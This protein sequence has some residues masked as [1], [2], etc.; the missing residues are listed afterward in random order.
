MGILSGVRNVVGFLTILPVGMDSDALKIAAKHVYL[1]PA[2]G[3]LIG[4]IV[5]CFGWLSLHVLPPLLTGIL[6]FG[7]I[8]VLS[9]FGH[10]DGLFDF[11]DGVMAM[12]PPKKKIRAMKD[13][14]VGAG[15]IALGLI[16]ILI[17]VFSVAE[18][19]LLYIAPALIAA[20]T[21][22]KFSM[23]VMA[24]A[25]KSAHR[26]L[27]T[28]FIDAMR[29]SHGSYRFLVAL[30][31]SI[32]VCVV[33]LG[34]MGLVVVTA[35]IISGLVM[36]AVAHHHFNGVAGDTFGATNEI[37]RAICIVVILVM[38]RWVW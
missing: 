15:G 36:T 5:G 7:F 6:V 13:L 19:G 8:A 9:G 14:N 30:I 20:E 34:P 18:T 10:I 37:T 23:V 12:G 22:A 21:S 24:M 29:G 11:G 31:S 16:V 26:G 4:F 32:V 25:G 17:T 28:Y 3:A 35:S 33:F 2:V 38:T 27:N 1:F